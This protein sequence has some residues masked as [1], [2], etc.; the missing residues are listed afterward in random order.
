MK[1]IEENSTGTISLHQYS[2]K[3]AVKYGKI[4]ILAWLL[5]KKREQE[6]GNIKEGKYYFQEGAGDINKLL[7]IASENGQVEVAEILI[8]RGANINNELFRMTPLH[9]ACDIERNN[10]KMVKFLLEKGASVN[11]SDYRRTPLQLALD[12][13]QVQ[14]AKILL[15]HGGNVD[16]TLNLA[17]SLKEENEELVEMILKRGSRE[18]NNDEVFQALK[19]AVDNANE[20]TV[21]VL[22]NHGF[23]VPQ[24]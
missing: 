4:E 14:T 22:L 17:V 13:K 9:R 11:G 7:H 1:L 21:R 12:N 19:R 5:E 15:E 23:R 16:R 10:E 24:Y 18:Y 3:G 6:E 2:F 20:K 8:R